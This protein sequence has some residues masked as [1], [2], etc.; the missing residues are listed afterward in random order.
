MDEIKLIK[1]LRA[2]RAKAFSLLELMFALVAISVFLAAFAPVITNSFSRET[3][4]LSNSGQLLTSEGCKEY[5]EKASAPYNLECTL[6]YNDEACVTCGGPDCPDGK[7]RSVS[8]CT[9]L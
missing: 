6:C 4:M 8:K 5:F 7:K 2:K 3:E 9:C 1:S